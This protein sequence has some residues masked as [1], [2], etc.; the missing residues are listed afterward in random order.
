[1]RSKRAGIL[2]QCIVAIA[3]LGT[4]ACSIPTSCTVGDAQ[5]SALG[6]V[7]ECRSGSAGEFGDPTHKSSYYKKTADS[8]VKQEDCGAASLCKTHETTD[9]YR[10]AI[11]MAFCTLSP[12]PEPQCAGK[13]RYENVCSSNKLIECNNGYAVTRKT[14]AACD[15]AASVGCTGGPGTKCSTD[16]EC[17]EGTTCTERGTCERACTCGEGKQCASCDPIWQV[18]PGAGSYD[19][20]VCRAGLCKH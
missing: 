20:L 15:T 18:V 10:S 12:E 17:A 11:T 14:C 7:E 16:S 13:R 6:V 3:L 1:M 4:G 5:C 9:K 2:A 19:H 8:W